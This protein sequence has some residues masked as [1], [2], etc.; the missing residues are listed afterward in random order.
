MNSREGCGQQ[1]MLAAENMAVAL[2]TALAL[3]SLRV[4]ERVLGLH[5]LQHQSD[6]ADTDW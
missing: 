5:I 2:P 1:G 6:I 4:K 3:K